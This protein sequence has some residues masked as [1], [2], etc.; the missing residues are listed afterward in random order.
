MD[1]L[2]VQIA[3]ERFSRPTSQIVHFVEDDDANA[4]LNNLDRYPHAYVLACLMDRQIKA[5]RAWAIPYEIYKKI[6]SFE[7]KE[8]ENINLDELK[9]IFSQKKLHRFNETMAEVFHSAVIDIKNKYNSNAA[10][11]WSNTPSSSAVVYRFLEFKGSGI[12]ISTMAANILARQFRVP[13]SDYYSIDISPDVHIIRVMK[14]MGFVPN[15]ANND[16]IIYKAREL[17]P[18]FP[19]IIDFSC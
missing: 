3:K 7:L 14:R 13:F 11:I 16:M 9:T 15:G 5:E 2:L 6:G 17:N 8:L 18:E 12:K 1:N 4:V 19:G 10:N